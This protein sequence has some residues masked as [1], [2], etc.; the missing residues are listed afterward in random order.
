EVR[1]HRPALAG[2]VQG[3]VDS[4]GRA[5]A[6]RAEVRGTQRTYGGTR[7][8]RRRLALG[9]PE[10]ASPARCAA[11]D[12]ACP[13]QVAFLLGGLRQSTDDIGRAERCTRM[14]SAA[15]PV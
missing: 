12:G 14:R 3:I 1:L 4:A 10:L 7:E 11:R 8:T 2:S 15:T 9:K 13:V 5:S 6:H